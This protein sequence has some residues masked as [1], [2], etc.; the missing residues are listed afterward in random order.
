MGPAAITEITLDRGPCFGTCPVFRFTATRHAGY[1]YEGHRYVE[2]LG[3]RSGQF[4]PAWFDRLAEL[5]IEL[6]I[7]DLDDRYPT[8]FEDTPSTVVIVRHAGG[9]K[10][11]HDDGGTAS[12]VRLWAFAV[13]IESLMRSA[14][15]VED[16]QAARGPRKRR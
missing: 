11:V 6:C 7:L 10:A 13:A 5:C 14:F 1:R 16:R 4:Y 3:K 9:V 12:P 8:D 2:P 15:E